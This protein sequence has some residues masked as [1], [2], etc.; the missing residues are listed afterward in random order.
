MTDETNLPLRPDADP[1]VLSKQLAQ[2]LRDLPSAGDRYQ[3]YLAQAVRACFLAV[4]DGDH[5]SPQTSL[6]LLA[7]ALHLG[8]RLVGSSEAVEA[9]AWVR[10]TARFFEVAK[11]ALAPRLTLDTLLARDRL[12]TEREVL[13]I[14]VR[15]EKVALRRG[16]I[17]ARWAAP[18]Q[19]PTDVRIGQI[20]ASF[21][22]TGLV[23]RVKQPARGGSDVAFYRLSRLGRELC[24]RL[25]LPSP[26]PR[27]LVPKDSFYARLRNA[28]H[29]D[30]TEPLYLTTFDDLDGHGSAH[31]FHEEVLAK[32]TEICRPV[33][34]IFASSRFF[35][36]R[37]RPLVE[38]S[39]TFVHLYLQDH[40]ADREPTIQV[41]DGDSYIYP[42]APKL[43]LT[44]SREAGRETWE[45]HRTT[46]EVA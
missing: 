17:A 40:V 7:P 43:A 35:T 16:E 26:E 44:M 13:R 23:V 10:A 5:E 18:H 34:W 31:A 11:E 20:L 12:E 32:L 6:D 8:E 24:E 37:F 28:L 15:A 9:A 14:L 36:E 2:A 33:H 45:Q 3:G 4:E 19:Q 41:L 27:N 39:G 1:K 29:V 22:E 42:V 25:R 46:A 30:T 38:D 21:H